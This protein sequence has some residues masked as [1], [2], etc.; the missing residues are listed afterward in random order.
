MEI[1]NR[2]RWKNLIKS[3]SKLEDL[4]ELW[5]KLNDVNYNLALFILKAKVVVLTFLIIHSDSQKL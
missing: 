5:L 2:S 3:K 1:D 4:I